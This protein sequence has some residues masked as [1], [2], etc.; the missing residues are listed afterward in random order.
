M[1]I[2][3]I[4]F[5]DL[6]CHLCRA[7]GVTESVIQKCWP[8]PRT[9]IFRQVIQGLKML[10]NLP[11]QGQ[12]VV[13]GRAKTIALKLKHIVSLLSPHG[14]LSFASLNFLKF[15]FNYSWFIMFCQ[16]LLYNKVTLSYIYMH[17]FSH[18]ILYHIPSQVTQYHSLNYI[19]SRISLLSHSKCHLWF[20]IWPGQWHIQANKPSDQLMI[21]R[22]N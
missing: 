16:F 10:H 14:H 9:P 20:W 21:R 6:P 7:D 17:S 11:N 8:L 15:F 4:C 5:L 3:E 22:R 19:Y 18:I 13:S 1:G 12:P 2:L